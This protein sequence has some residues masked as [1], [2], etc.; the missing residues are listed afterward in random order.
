VDANFASGS[1]DRPP[2]LPWHW[3]YL[4]AQIL[5]ADASCNPLR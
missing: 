5:P 4:L 3:S 1:I 2:C